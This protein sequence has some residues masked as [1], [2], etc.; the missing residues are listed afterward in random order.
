MKH[1]WS[2]PTCPCFIRVQSVAASRCAV[3]LRGHRIHLGD[4]HQVVDR[5]PF[6]ESVSAAGAGAVRDGRHASEAPEA[7]AVVAERLGALW[8][9]PPGTRLMCLLKRG[10]QWIVGIKTERVR[11]RQPL[12]LNF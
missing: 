5:D 1:G 10:D 12:T 3:H 4:A 7:V 6:I 9:C 2:W 11:N 8:Q